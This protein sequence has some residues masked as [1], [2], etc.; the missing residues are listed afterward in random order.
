MAA[1]NLTDPV[2]YV[3]SLVQSHAIT[4]TS[5]ESQHLIVVL[6]DDRTVT[7]GERA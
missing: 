4:V 7:D 3:D 6:G 2:A 5:P 1:Y